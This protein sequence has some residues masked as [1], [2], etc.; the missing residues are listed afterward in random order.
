MTIN[1][2]RLLSPTK[3]S[4]SLPGS[5]QSHPLG[6]K[7]Q[8]I[9]CLLS[10]RPSDGMFY[11]ERPQTLFYHRGEQARKSSIIRTIDGGVNLVNPKDVA[12]F[13]PL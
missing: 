4:L 2:P 8:L 7:L 13:P 1:T 6:N 11:K 5:Q 9:A 3:T 10:E 12:Y